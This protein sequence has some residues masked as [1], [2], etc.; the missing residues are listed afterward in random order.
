MNFIDYQNQFIDKLYDNPSYFTTILYKNNY[1]GI[2]IHSLINIPKDN[3]GKSFNFYL[4][5]KNKYENS[6]KYKS[7]FT[8]FNSHLIYP[9][10]I[11]PHIR[12]SN[13]SSNLLRKK[14]TF[15]YNKYPDNTFSYISSDVYTNNLLISYILNRLKLPTI[16]F[17]YF[18]LISSNIG[19]ICKDYPTLGTFNCNT[20]IS[21]YFI[22][23]DYNSIVCQILPLNH[24]INIFKQIITTL[25]QLSPYNF[26]Y[27]GFISS[28]IDIIDTPIKY[29][30]FD[31]SV[32][33]NFTCRLSNFFYASINYIYKKRNIRFYNSDYK[34][35]KILLNMESVFTI[36]NTNTSNIYYIIN[37][38][39]DIN[40]FI[41]YLR[42]IGLLYP[43]S[44]DIYTFIISLLL[45]PYIYYSIVSDTAF[46]K[47]FW[48]LLWFTDDLKKI[49]NKIKH[50]ITKNYY[51]NDILIYSLLID[52]KLK[53][54]ILDDFINFL[55]LY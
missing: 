31:I 19:Y 42:N 37:D 14:I 51:V 55:T 9:I 25:K 4:E 44:F 2:P 41:T 12:F 8:F 52:I 17:L 34:G 5:G 43:I 30:I 15:G 13:F 40:Q 46:F 39:I 36:Y 49:N 10:L 18:G 29:T 1:I 21:K 3:F 53:Y 32:D 28:Y 47:S 26:T 23:I 45:N 16:Y 27:G 33:S 35:T 11:S 6:E 24:I 22:D 38:T 54:N 48:K 7:Y 20:G 50:V